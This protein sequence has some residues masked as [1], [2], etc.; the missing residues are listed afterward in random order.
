MTT[1]AT[2]ESR[3]PRT[4]LQPILSESLA[5]THERVCREAWDREQILRQR[6]DYLT[7]EKDEALKFVD[8]SQDQAI[9]LREQIAT[10][11][12]ERDE[13]RKRTAPKTLDELEA[14]N[15]RSIVSDQDEDIENLKKQLAGKS[16][17]LDETTAQAARLLDERDAA[18][19]KLAEV[20]KERDALEKLQD[21]SGELSIQVSTLTADRDRLRAECERKDGAL[22]RVCTFFA[23][24]VPHCPEETALVRQ[25]RAA[26]AQPEQA[27][28][29][30]GSEG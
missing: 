10:L 6:I 12:K 17:Y 28:N 21:Q 2:P 30:G 8:E 29:A 3:T 16:K 13:A 24:S 26:L 1:P 7:K 5:E 20:E 23:G 14:V 22:E 19:A 25:C 15:L 4:P 18:L 11:R 27:G 9:K